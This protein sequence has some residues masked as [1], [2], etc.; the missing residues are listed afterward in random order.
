MLKEKMHVAVATAFNEDENLDINKTIKH[1]KTLHSQGVKSVLLSGTTGEQHSLTLE[2]RISILDAVE[3][4][5][6]WIKEMEIIM[7]VSAIRQKDA[8]KLAKRI[9]DSNVSAIMLGYPP[10]IIPTQEEAIKYSEKIIE[11]SK[12]PTVLYNNHKR[13]GFDLSCD[14]IVYLS[15]NSLVIGIKDPGNQEKMANIKREINNNDFHF[16]AG[17]EMELENKISW[18]YNRL[19][20][21]AGNVY[22]VEVKNWFE[23]LLTNEAVMGEEAIAVD[24]IRNQIFTGNPILNIKNILIKEYNE[25]WICRS[26]IGNGST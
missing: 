10:Y 2:E 4:E 3:N 21:I 23:K 11:L 15:K 9:R 17:G 6:A 22:P 13:T 8:E 14:S 19:S 20:S 5:E 25:V 7:G 12:K 18:G 26:P 16:Y 24:S 1:I